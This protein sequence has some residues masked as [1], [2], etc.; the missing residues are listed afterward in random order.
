[1]VHL[2][3]G[4]LLRNAKKQL[5]DINNN[6]IVDSWIHDARYKKPDINE[7]ELHISIHVQL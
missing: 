3:K 5:T 6:N 4:I 2:Y 7:S 1:M